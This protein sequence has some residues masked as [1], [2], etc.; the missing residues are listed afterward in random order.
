[1]STNI[2]HR[3]IKFLPT[4]GEKRAELLCAE[5]GIETLGDLMMHLPNR[6]LDRSTIYSIAQL[7]RLGESPYVQIKARVRNV[8]FIGTGHKGRLVVEVEDESSSANLVWFAGVNWVQKQIEL[9]REYIFFGKATLFNNTVS[10]VHPEFELPAQVGSASSMGVQGVYGTTEKLSASMLGSRAI[11][12]LVRTMWGVIRSGGY[13]IEETLPQYLL[14]EQNLMPRAEA[15]F[16]VH[17]PESAERLSQAIYR[18]KFEELFTIQ[19][20]LL[21]QK[22]VRI[23]RSQGFMMPTVGAL[24][25]D[26]Y[27]HHMPFELTGAQKRVIKQIRADL[28]STH[29]M[30]RLLQGDVGSGKTVVALLCMLIA[31]DN[32]YQSAIM[33]PTEILATQHYESIAPLAS[34]VGLRVELLTGSTRKKQRTTIHQGLLSGE[35]N[36]LIGT[37][38]LIEDTVQFFSLGFVVIDEQHRFGVAQRAKLW[39]KSTVPPHVLVMTATPI[40][41]TLA[42]TLYGDLDISI[43]D[44]LPPGRKPIKTIHANESH[45]L[46]VVGFIRE[47][48]ELGRQVYVVYPMIKESEKVDIANLEQGAEFLMHHFPPPHYVSVVVHGKMTPQLKE[49]GMNVF[50]QGQAQILISTTVIEVGVNVPNASVM[51][52]ESAQRFGLSQLHQLRGRVGRGADQSYCILMSDNKLSSDSRKRLRAMVET[53]DGFR[54]AEMDLQLRGAGDIEGTRQSGQAITIKVANLSKDGDIVA[55][56]RAIAEAILEQ[57]PTLEQEQNQPL[58]TLLQSIEQERRVKTIDYSKIS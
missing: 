23:T 30:N 12:A 7:E 39:G 51:V 11:S 26:F 44:E 43:I 34:K 13:I 28:C 8:Q 58:K 9:G 40:P 20:S 37:H 4:V 21:I 46:R 52:I 17:F 1:M 38:A 31:A 42:M 14:K 22:K 54:L 57:D 6:Y 29:Q 33:A 53:N 16:N 55:H 2:L 27:D 50:K 47:Q 25:N 35:I 5:L 45:R 18:L 10:M 36:I 41:R 24:F 48:I 56:G 3:A 49:F 15:L 32:G 19:L